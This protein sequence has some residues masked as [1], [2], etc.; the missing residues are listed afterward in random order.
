MASARDLLL[1]LGALGEMHVVCRLPS[2]RGAIEVASW[3]YVESNGEVELAWMTRDA[4]RAAGQA[5]WEPEV[6]TAT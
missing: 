5:A 6:E 1:R 4:L 3:S 2:Q